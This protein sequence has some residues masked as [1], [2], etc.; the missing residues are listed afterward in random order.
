[1]PVCNIIHKIYAVCHSL[2]IQ[3][4]PKM[5]HFVLYALT[6][7]NIYRFSNLFHYQNQENI[8]NDTVTKDLITPQ[9]CRYTCEMSVSSKQQLKTGRLL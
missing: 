2:T 7:S 5:A 6:S 3:G 4:G 1:M 8:C 9:V